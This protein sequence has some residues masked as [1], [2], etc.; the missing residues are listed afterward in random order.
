M[1]VTT[2][3]RKAEGAASKRPVGTCSVS[4][5]K[6]IASGAME[7]Q[8]RLGDCDGVWCRPHLRASLYD[9]SRRC[10]VM[11]SADHLRLPRRCWRLPVPRRCR[12]ASINTSID[13][14]RAGVSTMC[15]SSL[16]A[17]RHYDVGRHRAQQEPDREGKDHRNHG[18]PLSANRRVLHDGGTCS[19]GRPGLSRGPS[20]CCP[21]RG[22][23]RT[24]RPRRRAAL[25]VKAA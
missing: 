7:I 2:G 11:I 12:C 15:D 21:G 13:A 5:I 20:S 25:P 16:C 9:S 23:R 3:H 19:S 14:S 17:D 10:P 22:A 8:P 1:I 24:R 18:G 4:C 6:V